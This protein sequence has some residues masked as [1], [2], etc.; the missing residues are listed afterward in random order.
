MFV[1][2]SS[3]SEDL[4]GCT[5]RAAISPGPRFEVR[6]LGE[7]GMVSIALATQDLV[8]HDY[9]QPAFPAVHLEGH[10]LLSYDGLAGESCPPRMRFIR[11]AGPNSPARPANCSADK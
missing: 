5:G 8:T 11:P 6:E 2:G 10:A 1:F 7:I 3:V 9:P 4:C